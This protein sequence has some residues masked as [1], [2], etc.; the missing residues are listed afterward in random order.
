[1]AYK[2]APTPMTFSDLEGHFNCVTHYILC[3]ASRPVA[4][5]L[6]VEGPVGLL[7]GHRV[8]SETHSQ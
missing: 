1:V 3:L 6:S 2:M 7:G 5:I 8:I 4:R